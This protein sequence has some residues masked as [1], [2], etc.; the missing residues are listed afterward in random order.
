MLSQAPSGIRAK[1]RFIHMNHNNPLVNGDT[2]ALNL[3]LRNGF[4]IA[5]QGEILAL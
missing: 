5:R 2:A 3:V 4:G 1:I